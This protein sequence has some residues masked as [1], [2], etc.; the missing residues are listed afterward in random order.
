M[1]VTTYSQD[2]RG[3]TFAVACMSGGD[4]DSSSL[5]GVVSYP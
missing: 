2:S 4:S 3:I 1:N 5:T